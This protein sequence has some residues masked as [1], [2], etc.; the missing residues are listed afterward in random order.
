MQVV[1]LQCETIKLLYLH[2][3][4]LQ[5]HVAC[6]GMRVYFRIFVTQRFDW[7]SFKLMYDTKWRKMNFDVDVLMRLQQERRI[8]GIATKDSIKCVH[9]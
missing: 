4:M 3:Y 1:A 5:I 9:I 6:Q 8:N 7:I 2:H